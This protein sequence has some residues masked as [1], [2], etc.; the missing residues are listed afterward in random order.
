M[1][2]IC[3]TNLKGANISNIP[4]MNLM[5]TITRDMTVKFIKLMKF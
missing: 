4:T 3:L 1:G 5:L 2:I